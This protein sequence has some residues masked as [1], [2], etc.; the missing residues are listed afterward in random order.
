MTLLSTQG[1]GK[2]YPGVRALDA[3]DF[4]LERGEVH[5]L[6]GENGAGKST[7]ISLL[8][9]AARPSTGRIVLNGQP[10]A[11]ASVADARRAGISAVFQ[12]FSLVPTL[13][14]AENLFLGDEPR[15][16]FG[17]LAR[18]QALRRGRALLDDLQFDIDCRRPVATLSRAEQQMVE[19]AKGLH[20]RTQV[21]IL[22]EPT[23]SLTDK[24]T[25]RLFEIVRRLQQQGVG[26]VYISHRMQEIDAL[27]DR[28]T[29]LRDGRKVATV[30]ARGTTHEAL[31]EMMIG[32]SVD[33]LYP[34]IAARPGE[35]VLEM[36]ELCTASGVHDASLTVRAGEVLGV[37]GLVGSGKSALFRAA[38]GLEPVTAGSIRFLGEDT[39]RTRPAAMLA[40]GMAYLPPDRKTEGLVLGFASAQNIALPMLGAPL[41]SPAGSRPRQH[42]DARIQQ[43]AG[44]VELAPRNLARPV[45]L[46]SGGNQQK[47]LFAKGLTRPARLY[48]FDEPTV[49]VDVGTRAALYRLIQRLCEEGA[50]VVVV[51]SDLP[52]VLN[53]AHRVL[54]MCAGRVAGELVAPAIT[55]TRVLNLF[56]PRS[57]EAAA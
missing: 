36:R 27:A 22:D 10:V 29:V 38:F 45:G 37:A 13:S 42:R 14:V 46:L 53:L 5:V 57:T 2:H 48:V 56:F 12:E 11:F 26:I 19:I 47:V 6:F 24:E 3:V 35:V 16:R 25:Q 1:L 18:Q 28:I 44:A 7:L 32:R 40:R 30:P 41:P 52:E 50:A 15:G 4:E 39:T 23:A 49:G 34:T 33:H 20:A 9:G 51:S 54:V 31:V 21:F 8:A 17:L 43:A 55:E